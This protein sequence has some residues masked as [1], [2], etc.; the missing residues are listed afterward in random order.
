MELFTLLMWKSLWRI[1]ILES[2]STNAPNECKNVCRMSQINVIISLTPI[3]N[4]SFHIEE[5]FDE[6]GYRNLQQEGSIEIK[7]FNG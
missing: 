1:Q 2:T 3:S 6:C 7:S 4:V 5:G